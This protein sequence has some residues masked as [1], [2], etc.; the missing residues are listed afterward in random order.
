MSFDHPGV[1][2]KS[3]GQVGRRSPAHVLLMVCNALPPPGA[4]CVKT[5]LLLQVAPG[6]NLIHA[7]FFF[8][9]S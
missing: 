8:R 1:K 2:F 5:P 7:V 9:L 3:L 6:G 4:R